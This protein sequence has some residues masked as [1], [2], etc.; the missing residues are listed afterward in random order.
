MSVLRSRPLVA[1]ITA[2]V[3]SSFGS[4]MTFLALP[5]FVLVTTGS[6]ARM[7]I[8]FAAE[9]APMALLGIPSG[10]LVTRLGARRSMLV[11]DFARAPLI[12]AI[13]VLHAADAL[14]FPLLLALVA[15]VGCFNV[16]YFGAQRVVLPEIVG[17]DEQAVAQANAL[18]EGGGRL[19][20]LVGPSTAGLLIVAVGATNVIYID[21]ATYIV[22]FGLVKLLVPH[23][24]P[25]T[26]DE[27]SGGVL[28]GL[29]FLVRDRLLGPLIASAIVANLAGPAL[30]VGLL[31]L[32]FREYGHSSRVAGVLVAATSAGA[33]VGVV[34][35]L[36]LL[37][38]VPPLRLASA[39]FVLGSLPLWL[40]PLHVPVV[41]L[42][43]ALAVFGAATP[44]IN[45]PLI[46]VLTMRTPEA[47]R[48]KVMAAVITVAT[49]AGP[50]GAAAAGPLI[51]SIGVRAV[52]ALVAGSMTISALAFA[53]IVAVR[54]GDVTASDAAGAA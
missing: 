54:E 3:T 2:E 23:G 15:L 14:S 11:A 17:E 13:P 10:T 37:S 19:A 38:R 45:A 21:A 40:L 9:L 53:A 43:L 34:A 51:G 12:A 36:G 39:A 29:R 1:L 50:L 24:Q 28:A 46:G 26:R 16:P 18:V 35:S 31:A 32:A 4:Q 47:L 42:L 33:I 25:L 27:E 41:V 8:V 52:L 30:T 22:A 44:L 48:A 20:S 49:I 7:G 6:A 5:W